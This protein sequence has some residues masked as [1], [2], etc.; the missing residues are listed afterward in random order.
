LLIALEG[1]L[2]SQSPGFADFLKASR[3]MQTIQHFLKW[4]RRSTS[5]PCGPDAPGTEVP[6]V[7]E[8]AARTGKPDSPWRLAS[9]YCSEGGHPPSPPYTKRA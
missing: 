5:H 1:G 2:L 6:I 8:N 7:D 3:E 9:V 4:D